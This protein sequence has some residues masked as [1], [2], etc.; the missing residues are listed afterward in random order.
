LTD[1]L[2]TPKKFRIPNGTVLSPDSYVT[3]SEADFDPGGAGFS[4]DAE[5]DDVWL[6]SADAAGALTGYAHGFSYGAA[7]PGVSFGH[8]LT[9][10]GES[11]FVAQST[12]TLGTNNAPPRV[13]PVIVSEIMFRPPD[14]SPRISVGPSYLDP[15]NTR[16]EF[17]EM[18]NISTTNVALASW[19]LRDAVD[20]DFPSNA[21]LAVDARLLVVGF[22]PVV[23]TNSL[24]AF[25]AAYGLG[26]NVTLWGPWSGKL[27]NSGEDVN[28]AARRSTAQT[29]TIP[30]SSESAIATPSRGR[31][32]TEAGL[33]YNASRP[34]TTPTI[35]PTGSR[36][37]PH[38]ALRPAAARPRRSSRN[39]P[40]P[41]CSPI[42][43]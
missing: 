30:S 15:D 38:R 35:P 18:H 32:P 19:R 34:V 9:S 17:I 2:G 22:D 8:H 40:T 7:E 10:T 11:H 33:L 3:F 31:P 28:C 14:L 41:M 39:R 26:P 1:A 43:R 42:P 20:Y 29:P 4:L 21:N 16:D 25:R 36:R 27:D 37:C 5:G 13:G 24:A 6:F 12:N 23:D